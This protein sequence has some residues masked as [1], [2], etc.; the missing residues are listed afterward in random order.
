MYILQGEQRRNCEHCSVTQALLVSTLPFS[1][2]VVERNHI[3]LACQKKTRNDGTRKEKCRGS[4]YR[5]AVPSNRS[6][7]CQRT[8]TKT[9]KRQT[10]IT[11]PTTT[12]TTPT[13]N[14]RREITKD[15]KVRLLYATFDFR[16]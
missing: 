9:T 10:T 13:T 11:I 14:R 8:T 15:K 3:Y 1:T 12:T 2:L 5:V 6:T 16:F 7:N 4:S